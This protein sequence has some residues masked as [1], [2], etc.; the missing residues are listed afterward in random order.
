MLDGA[1]LLT[2]F[3]SPYTFQ[4]PTTNFVNGSHAVLTVTAVMRDGFNSVVPSATLNF[5]NA[6]TPTP[7]P[8]FVPV[9]PRLVS[10]ASHSS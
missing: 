5:S 6:A 10:K 8:T 1:Y 4:L 3:E 7:G 2:D 9:T